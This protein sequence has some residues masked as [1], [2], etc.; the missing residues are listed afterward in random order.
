MKK[1]EVMKIASTLLAEMK[2][3]DRKRYAMTTP[4]NLI[5]F[6]IETID[7]FGNSFVFDYTE[8]GKDDFD[9]WALTCESSLFKKEIHY[10]E[11]N[12]QSYPPQI[13]YLA[14]KEHPDY[15]ELFERAINLALEK[16]GGKNESQ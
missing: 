15:L 13:F 2:R 7:E 10:S 11:T 16:L 8:S 4:D 3:L 6:P 12:Y 14:E 9:C 1:D 5:K